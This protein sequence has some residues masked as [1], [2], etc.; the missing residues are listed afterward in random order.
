MFSMERSALL[1]YEGVSCFLLPLWTP[2]GKLP[3]P[4]P[5]IKISSSFLCVVN[6]GEP[7]RNMQKK[8]LFVD[9]LKLLF[10]WIVLFRRFVRRLGCYQCRSALQ[11][12]MIHLLVIIRYNFVVYIFPCDLVK[13]SQFRYSKWKVPSFLRITNSLQYALDR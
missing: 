9:C 2:V 1:F 12:R 8:R 4:N 5:R 11:R 7:F 3:V 6:S 13:I 10:Y